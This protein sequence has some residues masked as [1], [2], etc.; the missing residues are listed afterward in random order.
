MPGSMAVWQLLAGSHPIISCW[1]D[2]LWRGARHL[3]HVTAFLFVYL[4]PTSVCL[5]GW[6]SVTGTSN[7]FA[8][9]GSLRDE[10]F[11]AL[12]L[13]LLAQLHLLFRI[14]PANP[15][16][17]PISKWANIPNFVPYLTRN[18]DFQSPLIAPQKNHRMHFA[19]FPVT[20]VGLV[21][22]WHGM[23][24]VCQRQDRLDQTATYRHDRNTQSEKQWSSLITDWII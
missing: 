12:F 6:H 11:F 9:R 24:G 13:S 23:V 21:E 5:A 17:P 15:H 14:T 4:C 7:V 16:R 2:A 20:V 18:N 19:L 3:C 10:C 22:C 8:W 1:Q